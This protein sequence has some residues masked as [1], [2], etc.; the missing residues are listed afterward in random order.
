MT[1]MHN[2]YII[3]RFSFKYRLIFSLTSYLAHLKVRQIRPRTVKIS[4]GICLLIYN[5]NIPA[6]QIP[7]RAMIENMVLTS[8]L[9]KSYLL[10]AEVDMSQA[11]K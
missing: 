3:R 4:G 1:K 11:F 7:V 10:Q 2:K 8:Y 5:Y 9:D 6:E